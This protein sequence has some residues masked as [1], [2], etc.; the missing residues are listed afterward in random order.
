LFENIEKI[1]KQQLEF[2]IHIIFDNKKLKTNSIPVGVDESNDGYIT[3]I[4]K[5]TR[6]IVKL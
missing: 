6:A 5:L 3:R 4:Y 2:R 1:T